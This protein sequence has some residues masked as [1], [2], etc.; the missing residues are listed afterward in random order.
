MLVT[1]VTA[2]ALGLPLFLLA[3]PILAFWVG[4][5]VAREGTT[6]MRVLAF[7]FAAY[8]TTVVPYYLLNG[9]GF[10]WLS[11]V[12]GL[13]NGVLVAAVTGALIPI[14]GVAGAALAKLATFPISFVSRAVL[15]YQVLNDRRWYAGILALLPL[16][17]AFG[18][19]LG[20]VA[21]I[22]WPGRMGIAGLVA[23]G[24]GCAVLGGGVAY[25]GSRFLF[26]VQTVQ[27][28]S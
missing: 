6:T 27:R 16:V 25:L 15:H 9:A 7:A 21:L 11:S 18:V 17:L 22:G 4:D 10:V 24:L 20:A 23:I 5:E 1:T 13:A 14:T 28:P 3:D 8:G 2:S 19:G 26:P 12:S